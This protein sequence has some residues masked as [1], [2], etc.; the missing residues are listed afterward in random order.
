LSPENEE[1]WSLAIGRVTAPFGTKGEVRV[2]PETDFPER[3]HSLEEVC[4]ELSDGQQRQCRVRRSR[5]T[6]KGII[7]T[8]A[9][10]Q[11]RDQ[12]AALRSAWVKIKP[13]MAVPLA[14]GRYWIHQI[15]GL[16]VLTEDGED[17]GEVTEVISSPANDVYVT[18]TAMIPALRQVVRRVDLEAGRM[19]VCLP[20]EYESPSEGGDR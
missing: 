18:P 20:P 6:P 5:I 4:L 14:E 19:I 16:R 9:E 11:N 2:K 12:A 13:S 17:L 10:C 3:F 15:V 8:L 7:L 1:P